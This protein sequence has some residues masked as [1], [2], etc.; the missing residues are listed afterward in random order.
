MIHMRES[1]SAVPSANQPRSL[2]LLIFM[3][4]LMALPTVFVASAPPQS[5]SFPTLDLVG[6]L[7][8]VL[9]VIACLALMLKN[10]ET[11]RWYTAVLVASVGLLP[12]PSL[13]GF[14]SILPLVTVAA[15][16]IDRS[17]H[18]YVERRLHRT[19]AALI[20]FGFALSPFYAWTSLGGRHSGLWANP[21]GLA[22]A[23]AI[24]VYLSAVQ[25]SSTLSLIGLS[26]AL[27]S[28][29]RAFGIVALV[30][31]AAAFSSRRG[32]IFRRLSTAA[33][34]SILAF[35]VPALMVLLGGF[36]A[37]W[38]RRNA[39][40]SGR[41]ANWSTGLRLANENAPF[42][43]GYGTLASEVSNSFL[44]IWIEG[45][46]YGL[47][48]SLV[49]V[50]Y[51]VLRVLRIAGSAAGLGTFHSL[52]VFMMLVAAQVEGFLFSGGSFFAVFFWYTALRAEDA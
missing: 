39:G 49:M 14:A 35:G 29:G 23:G 4:S 16:P 20:I 38:S 26:A 50:C 24:L 30:V 42:G 15:V 45:G 36:G 44:L 48:V 31:F 17:H 37:V 21:N 5:V 2:A 6:V 25:R 41:E 10:R 27:L 52:F 8:R 12:S 46:Y 19:L 7:L 51:V 47:A 32:R 33:R 13:D 22:A 18:Q 11:L 34:R 1:L 28:G 3:V 9:I 43:T 40:L